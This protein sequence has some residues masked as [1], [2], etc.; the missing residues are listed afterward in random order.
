MY[1]NMLIQ[2][3]EQS[4]GEIWQAVKEYE[5][6]GSGIGVLSREMSGGKQV[7]VEF[8]VSGIVWRRTLFAFVTP[9]EAGAR[10]VFNETQYDIVLQ[11]IE[12]FYEAETQSREPMLFISTLAGTRYITQSQSLAIMAFE[13]EQRELIGRGDLSLTDLAK[14][15]AAELDS[16]E[17]DKDESIGTM[18]W[19]DDDL[20][21][22]EDWGDDDDEGDEGQWAA[23]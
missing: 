3:G 21:I 7:M 20:S 14:E 13:R 23:G 10:T 16:S 11:T 12:L 17:S 4:S 8:K 2:C 22:F 5:D 9:A 1:I 19:L 18:G 15:I 6:R